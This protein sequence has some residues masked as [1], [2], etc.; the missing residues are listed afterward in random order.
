MLFAKD[1]DK[2][3]IGEMGFVNADW[4]SDSLV[5]KE[6]E[7][8]TIFHAS[9]EVVCVRNITFVNLTFHISS[10][11]HNFLR[12]TIYKNIIPLRTCT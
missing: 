4:A 2:W 9:N 3:E 12:E 6:T 11:R 1:D 10:M 8:V 7:Y 5:K